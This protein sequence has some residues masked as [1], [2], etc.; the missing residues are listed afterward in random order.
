MSSNFSMIKR[1]S[2]CRTSLLFD[3]LHFV[4]RALPVLPRLINERG[5]E[6]LRRIELADRKPVEPAF[7]ATCAAPNP[8]PARVPL[9]GFDPVTPAG[10]EQE[11]GHGRGV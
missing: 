9:P 3:L 2:G 8:K 5:G 7:P 6:E 4:R 10:A 11:N 1:K